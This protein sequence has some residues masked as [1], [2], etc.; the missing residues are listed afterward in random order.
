MD[1]GTKPGVVKIDVE[2]AEGLV[3]QGMT[4]LLA[5]TRPRLIIEIHSETAQTDVMARLAAF[6]Y[7][8][9]PIGRTFDQAFPYRVLSLPTDDERSTET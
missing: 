9:Q 3:L 1:S 4:R 2:G 7:E 5:V 8:T 6:G